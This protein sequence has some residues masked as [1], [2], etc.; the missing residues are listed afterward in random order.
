NL[1]LMALTI[2]AGFV[3]DDA[4]V[5]IENIIR[6]MSE[7]EP[8]LQAAINGARQ[9][10]FTVVAITVALIA[11]LIPILFMPDIVGRYFREFGVT[12]VVAIVASAAVSL[13]LTP[14]LCGQLLGRGRPCAQLNAAHDAARAPGRIAAFYTGT[15]DWTLRHRF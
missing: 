12:L 1:S 2:A 4:I 11:A 3:V 13:T 6:R 8:A 10:A 15:L 9:M 7:G 14:M 5:M